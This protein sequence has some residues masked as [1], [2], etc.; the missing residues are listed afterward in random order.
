[1]KLTLKQNVALGVFLQ[2]ADKASQAIDGKSYIEYSNLTKEQL[3]EIASKF[4]AD[5]ILN[6]A[7]LIAA[8]QWD[9]S[10]FVMQCENACGLEMKGN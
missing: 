6:G 4:S 8:N 10:E 7:K 3:I 1:M 5:D 2:V 9:Q